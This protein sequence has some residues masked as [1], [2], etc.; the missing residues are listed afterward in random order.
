MYVSDHLEWGG[1]SSGATLPLA[2][3]VQTALR[4]RKALLSRTGK[5][6]QQNGE[7]ILALFLWNGSEREQP[8]HLLYILLSRLYST[9]FKGRLVKRTCKFC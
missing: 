7:G 6:I 9:K 4:R 8:V 1:P 2:S 5:Q 3:I